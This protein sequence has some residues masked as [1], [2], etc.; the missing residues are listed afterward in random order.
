[1]PTLSSSKF[2]ASFFAALLAAASAAPAL[3]GQDVGM[4]GKLN[5]P[6]AFETASGHHFDAGVYTVRMENLHTLLIQGASNSGF[7][8]ASVEDNAV[9]AMASKA[10]FLKY[11]DRYFMSNITIAGASRRLRLPQSH[12]ENELRVANNKTAPTNVEISLLTTGR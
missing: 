2:R 4:L 10:T 6:F 12:A 11:G 8:V 3:Q 1:M 5:V 7:A 9:P